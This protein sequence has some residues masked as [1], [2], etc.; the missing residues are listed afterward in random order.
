[1]V[2]VVVAVVGDGLM[3]WCV[4]LSVFVVI[5]LM[6]IILSG[7]WRASSSEASTTLD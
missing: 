1:M 2:I 5:E 6:V 7:E 3:L 4:A